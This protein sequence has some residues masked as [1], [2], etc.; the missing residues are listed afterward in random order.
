[1]DRN[2][3]IK[4]VEDRIAAIEGSISIVAKDLNGSDEFAWNEDAVIY[5]PASTIKLPILCAAY[6]WAR[7]GVISLNQKVVVR[8]KD[9]VGGCGILFEFDE[10]LTP[11][12]HDLMRI[13][14]AISDNM[15]TNLV[16]ETVGRERI[17]QFLEVAGLGVIRAERKMLD[18]EGMKLGQ[19]NCVTAKALAEILEGL[20]NRTLLDPRD[21]ED[22]ISILLSQQINT[23]LPA[24]VIE[25]WDL[26]FDRSAI[27]IAH[28][29][30][31]MPGV[32]H[33]V[34]IVF[35]PNTKFVLVVM[36]ENIDN[37]LAIEFISD[38]A[39]YFVDYFS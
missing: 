5:S 2:E 25:R 16:M 1:M 26:V 10:G 4:K 14:I 24:K 34:G 33:D 23:K 21:C 6:Y 7:K 13:M 35:M 29:T 3:L 20:V 37:D 11:T 18:P 15:A 39:K 38:T 8:E 30:G 17:R 9:R 12:L 36:T 32:E 27:K 19:I 31:D 22:A 28:K